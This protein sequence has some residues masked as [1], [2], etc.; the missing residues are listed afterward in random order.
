[1]DKDFKNSSL[2]ELLNLEIMR[3]EFKDKS[4]KRA[5]KALF[6]TF[7]LC[8]IGT[9]MLPIALCEILGLKGSILLAVVFLILDFYIYKEYLK[10]YENE[11]RYSFANRYK[12][13]YLKKY[14]N[15]LGFE[16]EKHGKIERS[17]IIASSLF[18]EEFQMSCGNDLVVGKLDNIDFT[19]CDLELK[20]LVWVD[21]K[22]GE[23]YET[24]IFQGL[25][26]VADFNKKT[27]GRIIVMP[28]TKINK[29][30]YKKIKMDNSEFNDEFSVF[31]SDIQQTMYILTPAFMERILR[32]KRLMKC[33]IS[34]SF[35]DNKIFIKIDRGHDSF[36]PN[37]D[38]NIIS[39]SIAP[40]IK[41]EL[42]AMFDIV[43]ILKLNSKIWIVRRSDE[44]NFL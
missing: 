24:T 33:P 29:N 19:F 2:K 9:V 39:Q 12:D 34:L 3:K 5:K 40:R 8:F 37:L 42:N 20:V 23:E 6:T 4:S 22:T 11:D 7:S 32:L 36:E 21:E 26:F 43:K 1:M 18:D 30:G 44:P 41:A 28:K 16:Y 38:K 31:G 35:L 15:S 17:N 25:F 13:F 10:K 14:I 27:Q